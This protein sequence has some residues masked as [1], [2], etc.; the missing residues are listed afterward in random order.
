MSACMGLP[1][2][3]HLLTAAERTLSTTE[4]TESCEASR[5]R[6]ARGGH[7]VALLVIEAHRF[8]GYLA[9]RIELARGTVDFCQCGRHVA[10]QIDQISSGKQ[11]AR[12]SRELLGGP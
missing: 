8:A 6:R 1:L 12:L 4:F 2:V 9:S 11:R 3:V 10:A 7:Q 5:L